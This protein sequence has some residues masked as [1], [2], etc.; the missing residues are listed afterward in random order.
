LL[1][2]ESNPFALATRSGQRIAERRTAVLF[3]RELSGYASYGHH[4]GN[5]CG[6]RAFK[7]NE[8]LMVAAKHVSKSDLFGVAINVD[9]QR[10]LLL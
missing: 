10:K 7:V 1:G 2:S 9:L 5:R 3:Q 4:D 8:T 6:K